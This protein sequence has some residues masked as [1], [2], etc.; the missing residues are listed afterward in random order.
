MLG[1]Q[2]PQRESGSVQT[3]FGN[4]NWIYWVGS[5]CCITVEQS[6]MDDVCVWTREQAFS[7]NLTTDEN[8]TCN[9]GNCRLH[10]KDDSCSLKMLKKKKK[11][12][13]L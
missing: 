1:G 13:T 3:E 7:T 5:V 8:D 6:D 9:P 4:E 12:L 2:K 11:N 10:N